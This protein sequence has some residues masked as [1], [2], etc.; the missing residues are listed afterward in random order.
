[1]LVR[2]K[3]DAYPNITLSAD[4]ALGML[5]MMGNSANVPCSIRTEDVS[6]ARGL[7]RT[8]IV[9][10]KTLSPVNAK[11]AVV[12]VASVAHRGLPLIDLLAAVEAAYDYVMWDKST[13]IGQRGST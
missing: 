3:T 9:A 6:K 12:P 5:T 2:F 7:L 1:M 8:A 11:D 4:D 10:S 13:I